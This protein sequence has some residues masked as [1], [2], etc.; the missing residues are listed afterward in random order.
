MKGGVTSVRAKSTVAV[1]AVV[2]L[3]AVYLAGYWP[4]RQQRLAAAARAE[5]LRSE[6]TATEARLRV[7]NLLGRALTLKETTM[8]QNYGQALD[9]SSAFFD[10]VRTESGATT[11]GGLRDS[12]SRTLMKR[13]AVTAALAKG[14][15]IVVDTLHDIEIQLRQ[16]LGYATPLPAQSSAL[17]A[18]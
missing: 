15:P 16:A 5:Q 12:L 17:P 10:Q 3:A 1:I 11:D 4:E 18:Q 8:T 6:L 7:G 13:D 14:D 9:L 2:V